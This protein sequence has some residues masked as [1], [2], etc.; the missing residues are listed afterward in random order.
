VGGSGSLPSFVDRHTLPNYSS[1]SLVISS[2]TF[3]KTQAQLS[4]DRIFTQFEPCKSQLKT[5]AA[6]VHLCPQGYQVLMVKDRER[7]PIA[8]NTKLP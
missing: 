1:L 2:K 8:L 7:L 5:E 3:A 4:L 6:T